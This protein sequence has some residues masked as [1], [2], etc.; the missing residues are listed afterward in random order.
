MIYN[1]ILE[2]FEYGEPIFFSELPGKSKD[3]LRQQIKKLVDNGNLERLYNGVYY[4]P[5]TTILGTKGRISIDKYIEKKYIQTNQET[6]GYIKGLQLANQYGFTT[7]NPSCY[8]ICSNEATTGYRRQEVDG[9][10]LIIYR[11]VREVNEENRASLQFLD[12][13][14]EIDKYCEISD[15]EKIRRIKKFVD[16]NNVDFKM[17]KE[18]LPFYPDKVYRNIYEGGVM[19]ELV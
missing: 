19:S 18:Y 5:Y 2:K 9:N 15:D 14:S 11:P 13:M 17:V 7:Q 1:Y 10:T 3:Y 8:E 4:L 6:K 16:I 12:L